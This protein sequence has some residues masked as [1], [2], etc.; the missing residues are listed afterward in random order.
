[1]FGIYKQVVMAGAPNFIEARVLVPSNLI[2]DKW[3]E[4]AKTSDNHQVVDFLTYGFPA[5]FEGEVPKPS[6]YNH[7]SARDHPRDVAIYITTELGHSTILGPFD[8]PHLFSLV[9]DKPSSYQT[10]G[11]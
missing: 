8:C 6:F 7:P 5:G 9:Q 10:Q 3:R 2:L 1:M 4:L 11:G